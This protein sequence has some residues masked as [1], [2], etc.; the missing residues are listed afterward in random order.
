MWIEL[1]LCV[2]TDT[3]E[4]WNFDIYLIETTLLA[5]A[6]TSLCGKRWPRLGNTLLGTR[7]DVC[8]CCVIFR[9]VRHRANEPRNSSQ[10]NS[11][12]FTP[13]VFVVFAVQVF[14][15]VY[16]CDCAIGDDRIDWNTY[17]LSRTD[18]RVFVCIQKTSNKLRFVFAFCLAVL[19]THSHTAIYIRT[20]RTKK[21][22]PQ[23]CETAARPIWTHGIR[24]RW[25]IE[26]ESN[27]L[28]SVSVCVV[29]YQQSVCG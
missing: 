5:F 12:I 22:W 3:L 27:A 18:R 16:F 25:A 1:C 4:W 7:Y 10:R 13:K 14:C 20:E 23:M 29:G 26:R 24:G 19:P 9:T 6:L 2:V 8:N 21:G 11:G 28:I 15:V 17:E